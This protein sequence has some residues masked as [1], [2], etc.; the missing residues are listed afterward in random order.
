[1]LNTIV[2]ALLIT[3]IAL[4]PLIP[5]QAPMS[6][7]DGTPIRIRIN[8]TISS[9]DAKVGQTVDFE[10][11]EEVKVAEVV[12]LPK[13]GLALA[14][15]TEAQSKKSMGRGGKLNVNIDHAKLV[16]G[17][18]VPLRAVKENQGGGH[19][20][21]MTGAMVATAIVFFPAAP[22]FLFMK[23]KDITIPKGT[24]VTAFVNGDYP[25]DLAKFR[26]ANV[27]AQ[28]TTAD[29]TVA[30][31]SAPEG[32]DVTV[33]GKYVGNTPATLRL[34]VGDHTV[35]IEKTGFTAWQRSISV[36]AGSNLNLSPTLEKV[37]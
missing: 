7:L 34:G 13:G 33:D 19:V 6:I 10:V 28:P 18:K 29:A 4:Q 26:P 2:N 30:I 25:I 23:G 12:V 37:P 17:D 32:A 9:A 11:L 15:V 31:N 20:G 36:T 8:Q 27:P 35:K 22:L 14:T 24:E 16:N 3:A 21:A 5:T 1:M